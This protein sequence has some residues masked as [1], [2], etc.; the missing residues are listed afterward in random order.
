VNNVKGNNLEVREE[1]AVARTEGKR[2]GVRRDATGQGDD[3]KP[4]RSKSDAPPKGERRWKEPAMGLSAIALFLAL[5][6]ISAESGL[7]NPV[8]ASKPTAVAA[9]TVTYIGSEVFLTDLSYT[10]RTFSIGLIISI[11]AGVSLGA[12][13]GRF[14][15]LRHF[16]DYIIS[17]SYAAPRIALVPLIILW[18]GIGMQAG[19]IIVV[20]IAIYPLIMN[21]MMAM[22]TI[23]PGYLDLG[24]SL[25]MS[26][27]Q[28]F[29]Y[30]L[31]PSAVP[32]ILTG[33]RLAIGLAL[34]G[35]VLAEFLAGTQG[36]GYRINEAAA[37]YQADRVLAGLVLITTGGVLITELVKSLERRFDRWRT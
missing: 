37:N 15:W 13:M 29:R 20:M 33:A 21:T 16:L 14:P 27:R 3:A 35:V 36:I 10:G 26:R 7:I 22:R 1:G 12:A 4:E 18:F 28:L 34:I 31:L 24:R 32:S 23:D 9:A 2:H 17:I 5:W 11:V 30:I 8:F 19:V 6:Q 25:K